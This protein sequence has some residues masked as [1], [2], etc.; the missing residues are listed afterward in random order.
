M[1]SCSIFFSKVSNSRIE[2]VLFDA[3]F[4]AVDV[5]LFHFFSKVSNSR[6]ELVLS[7]IG[8][9]LGVV[10]YTVSLVLDIYGFTFAFVFSAH[11]LGLLEHRVDVCFAESTAC[12]HGHTLIFAR[13]LILSGYIYNTICINVKCDFNLWDSSWSWWNADKLKVS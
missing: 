1:S 12:L 3:L 2:L 8:D 13:G 11:F 7:T 6:I 10:D 5:V 9:F 4:H